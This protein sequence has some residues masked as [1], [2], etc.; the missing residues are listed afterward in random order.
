M[1]AFDATASG[2]QYVNMSSS[3]SNQPQR[4]TVSSDSRTQSSAQQRTDTSQ[5]P[6]YINAPH[7]PWEGMQP[8][9]QFGTGDEANVVHPKAPSPQEGMFYS[10]LSMYILKIKLYYVFS[11]VYTWDCYCEAF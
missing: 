1:S 5:A 6:S 4:A 3:T 10:I 7:D 8:L 9:V 11:V 2:H